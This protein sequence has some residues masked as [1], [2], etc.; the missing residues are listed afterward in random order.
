LHLGHLLNLLQCKNLDNVSILIADLYEVNTY[1]DLFVRQIRSFLPNANIIIQSDY[2]SD[3]YYLFHRLEKIITVAK[4]EHMT[5]YKSK[6]ENG[7]VTTNLLTYPLLMTADLMRFCQDGKV[8]VGKDQFQHI[9][10]ANDFTKKYNMVYSTSYAMIEIH[11]QKPTMIMDLK[12]PLKKMSKSNPDVGTI[13]LDD[14]L[15]TIEK[16]ILKATTTDDG[17]KNLT[18]IYKSITGAE[19]QYNSSL[20]FKKSLVN[21]IQ[22]LFKKYG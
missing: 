21:V 12:D 20:D 10:Y 16:K 19:P 9:E 3:L 4:L 1:A 18:T 2:E 22:E 17:L 7:S 15:D 11:K 6:K 5:Q 13:Y 8:V 14:K